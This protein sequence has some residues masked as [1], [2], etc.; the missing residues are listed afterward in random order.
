MTVVS[1]H[2]A[3]SQVMLKNEASI[4]RSQDRK[5]RYP[6]TTLSGNQNDRHK[7]NV[8]FATLNQEYQI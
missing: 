1:P 8:N 3:Y 6:S 2:Q 7:E 5:T 4:N